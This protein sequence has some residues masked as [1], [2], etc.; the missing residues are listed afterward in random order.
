MVMKN[1]SDEKLRRQIEIL[2]AQ[3]KAQSGAK[4]ISK[5]SVTEA[6]ST[7]VKSLDFSGIKKDILITSVYTVFAIL[8]LV[9]LKL[10]EA[11][12]MNLLP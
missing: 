7:Q 10:F 12:W 1:S 9:T 11:K 6:T 8:G 3:V 4:V 2:R 5:K